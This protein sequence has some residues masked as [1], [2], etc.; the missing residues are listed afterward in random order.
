MLFIFQPNSCVLCASAI[1]A[2]A[3]NGELEKLDIFGRLSPDIIIIN[4]VC[5]VQ[6]VTLGRVRFSV[7]VYFTQLYADDSV[8]CP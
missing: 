2:E 4:K 6:Y 7:L 1:V 3:E 8:M 5:F